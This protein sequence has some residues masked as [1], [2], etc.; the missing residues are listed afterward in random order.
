MMSFKKIF[1]LIIFSCTY[2]NSSANILITNGLTHSYKV[3]NGTVQK[4]IITI[5]NTAHVSQNVKLNQ[6][7]YSYNA[8]GAS[9]YEDFGKNER[10]NLKW[11]T[12]STNLIK[13]EPKS[14]V[15]V[16]YEIKIPEHAFSGSC[17][18][19]VMVEP[20]DEILPSDNKTGLQIKTVVRYSIQIVTTNIEPA[21][22]LLTFDSIELKKNETKN[23]LQLAISNSGE[24]FQIV[25]TSIEIFDSKSGKNL[26]KFKSDKQSLLPNNS[27]MFSIDVSQI[28]SGN[29][30]ATV[31][32]NGDED[33]VF[34]INIELEIPNE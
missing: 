2:V 8:S 10:S 34:G 28:P 33:Y 1:L 20:V 26:G 30:S 31:L 17:W 16:S 12:L 29:Y 24:S 14:K 22:T 15:H 27:K 11:I 9:L 3:K 7:D 19:V 5:E 6:Q 21:K 18:S 4:G 25:D 32:A 13:I 23:F